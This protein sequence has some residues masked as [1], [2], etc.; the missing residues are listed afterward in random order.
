MYLPLRLSREDTARHL[1]SDSNLNNVS[2]KTEFLSTWK[3][4]WARFEASDA[5]ITAVDHIPLPTGSSSESSFSLDHNKVKGEPK[6]AL[7]S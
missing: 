2:L 3:R 7:Y 6:E 4:K 5:S 1:K